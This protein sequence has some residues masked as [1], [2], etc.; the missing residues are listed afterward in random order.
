MNIFRAGT[1][2]L[3]PRGHPLLSL[4]LRTKLDKRF[5]LRIRRL[6]SI[7]NYS[8]FRVK[9]SPQPRRTFTVKSLVEKL[10]FFQTLFFHLLF[11]T[12]GEQ[13]DHIITLY[14]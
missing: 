5:I 12:R 4:S 1:E 8:E 9:K 3:L 10:Y 14:L 13:R 11:E 7:N 2:S 6:L